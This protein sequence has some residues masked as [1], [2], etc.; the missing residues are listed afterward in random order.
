MKN[1]V[2][3]DQMAS[4]EAIWS[5]STLFSKAMPIQVQQ[6]IRVKSIHIHAW[7]R[8][9]SYSISQVFIRKMPFPKRLHYMTEVGFLIGKMT[10][11]GFGYDFIWIYGVKLSDITNPLSQTAI[12]YHGISW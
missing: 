1:S 4:L 9:K 8:N 7:S 12:A 11:K 10:I 6:D 2:D 3:P 5:G